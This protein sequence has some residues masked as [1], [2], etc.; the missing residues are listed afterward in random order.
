M[1]RNSDFMLR[2]I[3]GEVVLVPTGQATQQFNGLITLNEVAAFIWKNLDE[4]GTREQLVKMI[5]DEF[6][7][8]QKTAEADVDGFINALK[9]H[10]MI[11]E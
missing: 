3:A 8:D 6:E 2:D 11:V 1:K 10:D 5:L 7:V 4:A 9:E